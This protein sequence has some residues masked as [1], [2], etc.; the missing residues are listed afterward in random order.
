MNV[1]NQKSVKRDLAGASGVRLYLR[2]HV[3]PK[4]N[5]PLQGKPWQWIVP[6]V[7]IAILVFTAFYFLSA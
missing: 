4:L 3:M 6:V 7:V 5:M 1:N 2:V